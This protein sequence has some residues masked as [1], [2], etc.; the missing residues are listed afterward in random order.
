MN[1]W[2]SNNSFFNSDYDF[3]M[4]CELEDSFRLDFSEILFDIAYL[5]NN[6]IE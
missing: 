5:Y 2:S 6:L 4:S 3:L 1:L